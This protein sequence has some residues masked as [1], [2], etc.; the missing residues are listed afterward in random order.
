MVD[1]AGLN[2]SIPLDTA[3]DFRFKVGNNNDPGTW[4]DAPAPSSFAV[5]PN[6]GEDECRP[7]DD[8]LGRRRIRTSGSR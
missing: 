3:A 1:I 5:R 4:V 7:R 6:A 2:P 8:L